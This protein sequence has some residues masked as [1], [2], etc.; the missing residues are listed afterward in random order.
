MNIIEITDKFPTELDAIKYFEKVRWGKNIKCPF[1][2]SVKYGK[3]N[4]DHRFHCKGCNKSFSVTSKTQIHNTRLPVRR[5]LFAFSVITDAKKGLS[6][7]QLQRNLDI[8]Y[9]TAWG[10]YHK[11]RTFMDEPIDKLE[12]IVEIDETYVGGKPRPSGISVNYSQKKMVELDKKIEALE[13]KHGV[14]FINPEAKKKKFATGVKRGRGTKKI[15]VVGIVEREGN[16]VAQVMRSLT[17]E[18][19]KKM[20]QKNVEEEEAV[21]ITDEFK[22]YNKLEKIIDKI[23]IEHQKKVYSYKGVNTNTI[24]SFWA[25]IKRGII[26]QYHSV[27]PKYLPNYIEEFVFKFN[28]RKEDDMFETLVKNSMKSVN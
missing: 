18:N 28:N 8:S 10:M 9:P 13:E 25:I 19:L 1:C 6:A 20:V 24:E 2:N 26:G 12:D 7:L 3:R 11:I 14:E 27:S 23:S 16:V 4:K 17:T 21:L 22:S 15:P 5:W